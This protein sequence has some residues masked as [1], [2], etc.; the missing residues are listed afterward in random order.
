[1]YDGFLPPKGTA[2]PFVYLGDSQQNDTRTKGAVIGNVHQ[3]IH[4]WHNNPEQR[5]TVSEMLLAVKKAI[6]KLE[7]L[8][9]FLVV[10]ISTQI[11]PDNTTETPLLHGVVDAELK[12]S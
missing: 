11:L 5:G 8:G 12:F 3:T 7:I 2:Y 1:M 6:W 9:G 10:S 4:I